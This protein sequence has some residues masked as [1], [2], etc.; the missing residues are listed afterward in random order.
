MGSSADFNSY[1]YLCP[2]NIENKT[3]IRL[4]WMSKINFL[5]TVC[6]VQAIPIITFS[7]SLNWLHS[8]TKSV[9]YNFEN[10]SSNKIAFY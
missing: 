1:F 4:S 8:E 10:H 3:Y 7:S 2:M 6:S 5:L 9:G